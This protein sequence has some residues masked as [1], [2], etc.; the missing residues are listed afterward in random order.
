MYHFSILD[1]IFYFASSKILLGSS[2]FYIVLI[3]KRFSLYDYY[4][5]ELAN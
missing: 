2:L 5:I 4:I 1:F 3:F